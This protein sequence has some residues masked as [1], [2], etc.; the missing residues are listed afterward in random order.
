MKHRSGLGYRMDGFGGGGEEELK[1]K[2]GSEKKEPIQNQIYH[3]L[4]TS[5]SVDQNRFILTDH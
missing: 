3:Q 5:G 1:G 2:G 4:P